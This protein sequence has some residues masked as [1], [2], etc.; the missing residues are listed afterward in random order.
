MWALVGFSSLFQG[1]YYC[2]QNNFSQQTIKQQMRLIYVITFLL[3]I[4]PCI[5]ILFFLDGY[6]W[7]M[8]ILNYFISCPSGKTLGTCLGVSAIFRMSFALLLMFG[9]I[10]LACTSKNDCARIV[11]E[12]L[13]PVK[14]FGIIITF[15]MSLWINNDF[16]FIYSSIATIFSLFFLLFQIIMIIDIC[17][18]CSE[19][20]VSYYDEGQRYFA[21]ILILVTAGLYGGTGYFNII[22]YECFGGCGVGTIVITLNL[23]FI[24][25]V[26]LFTVSGIHPN[27]SLLTTGAIS[28]FT[29][30]MTWSALISQ[31]KICENWIYHKS[32]FLAQFFVGLMLIII[33]LIYVSIANREDSSNNIGMGSNI[34]NLA[35]PMLEK[36]KIEEEK[37][38]ERE[39]DEKKQDSNNFQEFKEERPP[40]ATQQRLRSDLTDYQGNKYL[41]FHTIMILASLYIPLLLTNYGNILV[42]GQE[43]NAFASDTLSLWIKLITSWAT[44]VLYVW[45]LIAPKLFPNRSFVPE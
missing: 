26:T 8:S 31:N 9:L 29:T 21:F 4:S 41:Y 23:I 19:R 34:I 2:C 30:Y 10:L 22:L 28:I 16:F 37:D 14:I 18:I 32:T 6:N 20:W 24:L 39:L 36:K 5:L 42:N 27:G 3:F 43:Y 7:W 11:N 25:I 44:M 1:C 15:I 35:A 13:W 40:Q 17:Y 45:T 12:E 33:S 38:N